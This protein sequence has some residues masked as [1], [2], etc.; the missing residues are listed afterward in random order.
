MSEYNIEIGN[1]IKDLREIYEI[2]TDEMCEK[3]GISK[4]KYIEYEDGKKDIPASIVYETA[5]IFNVDMGLLL[6]GEESR[7]SIFEVTRAGE[8]VSINR[9]KEYRYENLCKKFIDKK[10]EMFIVTVDPKEDAKPSFNSHPG[11]EFNYVLEGCLK[12]YIN[13]NEIILNKGDC[14]FFD[15]TRDHAMIALD[16]EKAKFLAVLM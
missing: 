8:G 12:L 6:T 13:N 10:A 1:R 4:E 2:S 16:N 7:M 15:S 9:R 14:V 11:Q 3:L 5:N